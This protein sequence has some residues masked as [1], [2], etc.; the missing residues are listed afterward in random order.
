[1]LVWAPG[2]GGLVTVPKFLLVEDDL[3]LAHVLKEWF[4]AAGH[5]VE[6]VTSGEDALQ[7]LSGF[8]FDLVLL[9]WGLPGMPGIEVCTRFRKS[10][11][12]TYIIFITGKG[13]INCKEE[14][15]GLGGD[16]YV[17]KPF[18]IRELSA[19]VRSVLRRPMELLSQDLSIDDVELKP[20]KRILTV[21]DRQIHLMPK[22]SKLLEYLMRHP[23]RPCHAQVLLDS[24]WPS[25]AEATIDTIRTWMKNLRAKLAELGKEEF[26]KT[27]PRAG[28]M[29]ECE[30]KS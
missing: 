17:V 6:H 18:D 16:D 10:G 26:I 24:V 27:I 22:E 9:D 4:S 30:D 3:A 21:G 23:N 20:D 1:V 25:E 11:G 12:Q 8:K 7:M 19:R 13:E 29:I 5:I 14:A 15:L 2:K 28:Y